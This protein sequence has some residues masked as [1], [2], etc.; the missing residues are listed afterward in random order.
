MPD[1]VPFAQ[2]KK[3]EKYSW[4]FTKRFTSN[5]TKIITPTWDCTNCTKSRKAPQIFMLDFNVMS[6][7]IDHCELRLHADDILVLISKKI[8]TM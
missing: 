8:L 4:R 1:L 5:F 2:F 7:V 3:R 6:S